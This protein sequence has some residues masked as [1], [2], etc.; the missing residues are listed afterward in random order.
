MARKYLPGGG[1]NPIWCAERDAEMM[2]ENIK[3]ILD[4]Y[5]DGDVE[6]SL[7]LA[8]GINVILRNNNESKEN[9]DMCTLADND[10]E[11][12]FNFLK[13][14]SATPEDYEL[15]KTIIGLK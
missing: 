2:E 11:A 14:H 12:K 8:D 13:R 7:E 3:N 10:Y 4:S 9:K 5:S 15:A 6:I 1:L